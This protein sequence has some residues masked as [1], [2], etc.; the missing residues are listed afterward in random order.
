MQRF[1]SIVVRAF[2]TMLPVYVPNNAAVLA[3]GGRPID[4]GRT[5][6]GTRLLGDG[7][8]WR[9][10][11]VGTAYGVALALVL[12]ALGRPIRAAT[13]VSLPRF[14]RAALTLPLGA[15]AGDIAA[16]LYKRRSG[17]E[18]GAPVVG[19]DQ[20]D[21]VFGALSLTA[22]VAPGWF[23]RVFRAPVLVVVL[24]LTPLLHIG[25]NLLAYLTGLKNEPY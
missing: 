4:G 1:P 22:C 19:L 9:G 15:I 16:S 3:G 6:D 18:R 11:T 17:R 24:V 7:K 2:W 21:F 20:L 14:G 8:T 12:N 5:R 13:G 25:S 23:R 10:A